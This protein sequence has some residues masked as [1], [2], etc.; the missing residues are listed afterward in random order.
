M[1]Y[2]FILAVGMAFACSP[3]TEPVAEPAGTPAVN[4]STPGPD[5]R[6]RV[7]GSI[8]GYNEGD[9]RIGVSVDGRNVTVS[10]TTYGGGCHSKGET[11][12]RVQGMVA[13]IMPYD[14]TAPPGTVCTQPLLSFGHTVT[15]RFEAA[16]TARIRIHGIDAQANGWQ[17]RQIV[18][19]KTT[20]VR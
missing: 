17:G 11:E 20:V 3:A 13:D 8:K 2:G 4:D 19:E 7:L 9:P 14:Y 18:V 10:V 15:V 1:R 12:V 5:G 16:G 6:V